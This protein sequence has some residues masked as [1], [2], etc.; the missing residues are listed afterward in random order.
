MVG[1]MESIG[2]K[3]KGK[4]PDGSFMEFV[5]RH[6]NVRAKIHPPDKVTTNEHLHIYDRSESPLDVNL[7]PVPPRDP[8]AHIEIGRER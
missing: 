6:G 7:N 2:L 3:L 5:D 4:S 1:D 8:V